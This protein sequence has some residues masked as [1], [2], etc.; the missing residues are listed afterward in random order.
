MQ[1]ENWPWPSW[2][3]FMQ[4]G[5]RRARG[6][7]GFELMCAQDDWFV[8]ASGFRICCVFAAEWPLAFFLQ[9]LSEHS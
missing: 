5:N 6:G 8:L 7:Q 2:G 4:Q 9:T 3:D 1:A